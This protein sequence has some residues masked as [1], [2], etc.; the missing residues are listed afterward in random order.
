MSLCDLCMRCAQV[1]CQCPTA[2]EVLKNDRE[3]WVSSMSQ[4]WV[5]NGMEEEKAKKLADNEYSRYERLSK[6]R[7][8]GFQFQS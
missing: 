2:D 4:V 3:H 5:D 1:M 6:T 8:R 7:S